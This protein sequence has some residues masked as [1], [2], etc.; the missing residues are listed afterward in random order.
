MRIP[1]NHQGVMPYLMLNNAEGFI[2][3]TRNVFN[4]TEGMKEM[5][6]ERP[7]LIMHAEIIIAGSTIM[8]ADTDAQWPLANANLF[9]YVDSA[10]D[11]YHLALLHGAS[12][13]MELSDQ[14]Y[15]RTCGVLDP[16][17]N[18]WW[19]TSLVH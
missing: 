3:F 15:G 8:F 4:A 17:G 19:I 13:V 11:T 10:D 6:D 7:D 2:G 18:T 12:T 16:F 1:E 9:V 5:R 14:N